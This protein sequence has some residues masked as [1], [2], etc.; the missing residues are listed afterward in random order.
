[1]TCLSDL[2]LIRLADDA[3]DE[4]TRSEVQQ[5]VDGCG[6]CRARLG[7]LKA[8]RLALGAALRAAEP[9]MEIPVLGAPRARAGALKQLGWLAGLCAAVWALSAIWLGV[10]SLVNTP[11]FVAWLLPDATS[12]LLAAG[13][14]GLVSL[15]SGGVGTDFLTTLRPFALAGIC[16]GTIWALIFRGNNSRGGAL[17]LKLMVTGL[18]SVMAL[19]SQ[20]IE[21]RRDE[22]RVTV[23]AAERIDDTLIVASETVLIEGEVTGDLL[24]FG[25]QIT[26]RGRVG[27]A[28]VALG[29]TLSLD[30]AAA[31]S[32]LAAG[33]SVDIRGTPLGGNLFAVGSSVTVHRDVAIAGNA[34][35]GGS[36]V[37][38]QGAVDRDLL[39]LASSAVL[40]GTVAGNHR[41]YGE[42]LELTDSGRIGGNLSG[43]LKSEAD[44]TVAPAA[45]VGGTTTIE[46]WP[47]Q[48]S[49]YA[50][51][52]FYL[53]E[54]LKLVAALIAGLALYRLFPAFR[55]TLL[56]SGGE[57]LTV[58]AFGALLLFVVPMA[59]MVALVTLILAPLGIIT[60]LLWLIALYLAGIVIAGHVGRLLLDSEGGGDALPLLV[61]LTGL[62]VLI[63][64]PL[65]GGPIRFVIVLVG[66]GLMVQIVR[67]NWFTAVAE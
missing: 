4:A 46:A 65:L 31:G 32:A 33:E 7:I 25:E 50:T 67:R 35:I 20:A 11:S 5:R 37:D 26:I 62:F 49:R 42:S 21:I 47:E 15:V 60:L 9:A 28:I 14:S 64:L 30:G 51:F 23:A 58:S 59:A 1:M 27:G 8:E 19:P 22:D 2:M 63:N 36:S 53:G 16:V 61:G 12:V 48:P 54:V 17:C 66:L 52:E 40:S 38:Q 3:L 24:V 56:D 45:T 34:L 18:L 13:I 29:E 41:A 55:D 39:T 57:V 43:L 44:L 6:K 10:T